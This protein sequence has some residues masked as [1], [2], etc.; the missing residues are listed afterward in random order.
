MAANDKAKNNDIAIEYP[1]PT[2]A[3]IVDGWM[4]VIFIKKKY[5]AHKKKYLFFYNYL[6][7]NL[8]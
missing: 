1:E 4:S 2:K 3:E 8:F 5:K 6:F 7:S